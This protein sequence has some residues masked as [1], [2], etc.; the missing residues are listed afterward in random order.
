MNFLLLFKR[1][2][3]G[4]DKMTLSKKFLLGL[5]LL[6]GNFVL[7]KLALPF[8]AVSMELGLAIY[9]F[10][11]LMFIAGLVLCGREGLIWARA[12]YR[13]FERKIR[14]H[15]AAG[16]KARQNPPFPSGK[17]RAQTEE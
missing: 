4:E 10:S 7:G 17:T 14:R 2:M 8:F 6:I 1:V 12:Y 5:V 3:P 11:W 16:L 13:H 9:L 15:L